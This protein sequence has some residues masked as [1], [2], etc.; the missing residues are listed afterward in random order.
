MEKLGKGEWLFRFRTGTLWIRAT[1][2][3]HVRRGC[4]GTGHLACGMARFSSLCRIPA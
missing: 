2:K 4:E 3:R 1:L